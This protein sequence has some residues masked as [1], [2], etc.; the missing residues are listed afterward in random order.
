MMK[1]L[2]D[3]GLIEYRV[4]VNGRNKQSVRVC[5]TPH[6]VIEA[7]HVEPVQCLGDSHRIGAMIRESAALGRGHS[8]FDSLIWP[9]LRDLLGAAVG[10]D[11]A[12]KMICQTDRRLS[13]TRSA[14]PGNFA[15][16]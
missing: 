9:G 7:R 6:L 11:H 12:I 16:R 3:L 13:V 2:V 4:A 15:V 5:N 10:S 14:I 8:V 1:Y